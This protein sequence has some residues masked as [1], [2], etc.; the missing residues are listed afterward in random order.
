VDQ[1]QFVAALIA[2]VLSTGGAAFLKQLTKGWSSLRSGARAREREVVTDLARSRDEAE[3]RCRLAE[4]D[5]GY[6]QRIANRYAGQLLR[7]G[8]DPDPPDPLP[9]S[10]RH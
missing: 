6:W 3:D 2:A 4:R 5:A 7:A 1:R 9:P 8:I 10:E